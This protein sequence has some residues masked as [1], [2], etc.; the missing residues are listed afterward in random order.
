MW[1]RGGWVGLLEVWAVAV[2]GLGEGA[3]GR[4]GGE[5]GG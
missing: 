1:R 2:G 4:S 3:T 5:G